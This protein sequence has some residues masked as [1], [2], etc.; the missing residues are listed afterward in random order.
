MLAESAK[1][2]SLGILS[3]IWLSDTRVT[4]ARAIKPL[5]KLGL[6]LVVVVPDTP[7]DE[8]AS[9]VPLTSFPGL[10]RCVLRRQYRRGCR[11]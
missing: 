8:R 1:V 2:I 9:S 10:H 5:S 3:R 11:Q 4:D 6:L 7:A